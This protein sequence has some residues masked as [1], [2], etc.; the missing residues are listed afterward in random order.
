M[1]FKIQMVPN[2][3][4]IISTEALDLLGY[5]GI[6]RTATQQRVQVNTVCFITFLLGFL[7]LLPPFGIT[8]APY[9]KRD[10]LLC[11]LFN[12]PLVSGKFHVKCSPKKV[13]YYVCRYLE[14]QKPILIIAPQD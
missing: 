3:I 1:C 5:L 11:Y 13:L 7:G 6:L 4:L 14:S 8:S 10:G 9:I 12:N 2:F